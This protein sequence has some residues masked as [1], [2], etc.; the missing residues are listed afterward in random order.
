MIEYYT[1]IGGGVL[2]MENNNWNLSTLEKESMDEKRL[3]ELTKLIEEGNKAINGLVIIKNGNEVKDISFN[4]HSNKEKHAIYSCSESITS[5]LIGK[6]IQQGL[7]K[8]V[9]QKVIDFFPAITISKENIEAESITI[10]NLLTMSTGLHWYDNQN[11]DEMW[12]SNSPVQYFFNR[13][14]EC[15]PGTKF[16]YCSGAAHILQFILERVTGEEVLSFSK[17]ILFDPLG[18]S[19]VLWEKEANGLLGSIEITPLDMAKVGYMCLK[20]GMWNGKELVPAH[21]IK[22]STA[23]HIDTP[24][25]LN[26][27]TNFGAGYGY[28]WWRNNLGGFHAN[29][30]GGQYMFVVPESDLVVVFTGEVF[31]E[32]FFLP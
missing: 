3:D 28:L 21:W 30:F 18:I 29:G 20:N 12:E 8:D 5:L 11:Y 13:P 2:R 22:A 19:E 15:T 16:T 10:E 1:V 9:N 32:D 4:G 23:K 14:V 24:N 27:V 31:G 7:I 25:N 26:E 6:C 17:K